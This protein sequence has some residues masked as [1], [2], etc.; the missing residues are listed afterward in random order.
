[1][2]TAADGMAVGMT[3]LAPGAAPKARDKPV[4]MLNKPDYP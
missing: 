4:R 1:M 3:A 2:L